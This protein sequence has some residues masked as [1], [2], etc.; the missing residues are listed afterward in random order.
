ME[1]IW[2]CMSPGARTTRILAMRGPSE[3][4]LK[5]HLSLRPSS[6]R[7]VVALLETLALWE[8]YPVRAALVVDES[9]TD[10]SPTTLYRDTFALF[11]DDTPLYRLE[12]IPR[13]PARRRSDPRCQG[14]RA[15][16][17]P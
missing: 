1:S 6:S 10:S 8:D 5:A 12:W 13:A 15:P 9:S 2:V 17:K 11:G 3:T 16:G 7:A 14:P 4:I